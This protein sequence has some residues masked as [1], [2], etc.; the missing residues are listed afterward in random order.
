[1]FPRPRW[2]FSAECEAS[3]ACAEVKISLGS[4]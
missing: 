4:L 2:E 3:A 1:M